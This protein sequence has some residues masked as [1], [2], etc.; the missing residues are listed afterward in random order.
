MRIHGVRTWVFRSLLLII[1]LA[2]LDACGSNSG[3]TQAAP[4]SFDG[5]TVT[6]IQAVTLSSANIVTIDNNTNRMPTGTIVLYK[7]HQ[8]R[9]GKFQVVTNGYSLVINWVTYN[10]ANDGSIYSQGNNL[11]I[12]G[13][14]TADLDT[15]T[16]TATGDDF[17]WQITNANPPI[18]A[19]LT[20]ENGATFAVYP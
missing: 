20:P 17:W 5:I 3:T 2:S 8:G 11:T 13:T 6:D 7:T 15:G 16:V 14:F 4:K 19:Y 1:A 12:P 18:Q 10:L 9:Y